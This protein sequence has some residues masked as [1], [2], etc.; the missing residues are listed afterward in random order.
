MN[1]L[2][3]FAVIII[4]RLVWLTFM[5]WYIIDLP[6]HKYDRA[7]K[8]IKSVHKPVPITKILRIL[9]KKNNKIF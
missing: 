3:V 7:M 9:K 6:K 8:L 2:I 1:Y 4:I 5:V